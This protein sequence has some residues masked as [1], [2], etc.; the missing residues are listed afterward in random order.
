[1]LNKFIQNPNISKD[2][3][4]NNKVKSNSWGQPTSQNSQTNS[5]KEVDDVSNYNQSKI[6]LAN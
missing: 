2:E 1:M 3:V 4:E 5:Q 6:S